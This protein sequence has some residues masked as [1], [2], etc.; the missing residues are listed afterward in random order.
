M[1]QFEALT[2]SELLQHA[3]WRS[4]LLIKL[5]ILGSGLLN[6][7]VNTLLNLYGVQCHSLSLAHITVD[8]KG[9]TTYIFLPVWG[10]VEWLH[11]SPSQKYHTNI[12]HLHALSA[13]WSMSHVCICSDNCALFLFV[14]CFD[15]QTSLLCFL[16][17]CCSST[18]QINKVLPISSYL[19]S[20]ALVRLATQDKL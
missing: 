12:C 5:D 1:L 2:I 6:E 10:H 16:C 11:W 14:S 7:R 4:D 18:S 17:H 3:W 13:Q 19:I 15:L 20:C 9:N 8:S